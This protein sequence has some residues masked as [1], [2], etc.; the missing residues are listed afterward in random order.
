MPP[1]LEDALTPLVPN[2]ES[3]PSPLVSPRSRNKG[4]LTNRILSVLALLGLV[5]LSLYFQSEVER[6]GI[7]LSRDETHIENLQ[8]LVSSQAEVIARF[9]SSITNSDVLVRLEGLEKSLNRTQADLSNELRKTETTIESRLSETLDQLGQTVAAAQQEIESD[10]DK[11]KKDVESYVRSTQ[12]QFSME[13][14]FMVYQLAGTFTLLSGLI[15]MWHMTAHLRRFNQPV[16]QR[17]ILA[18]LWMCPIYA[19]TSWFSLVFHKA[20]GYLGIVKDFYEAYVIYQFLSFCIAVLGKGDREAVVNLLAKHARHLTPPFRCCGCFCPNPYESDRHLSDAVLLQCQRFAMQ[21]V[22][23]KPLTAITLFTLEKL[24]YYGAGT[25]KTDYRSPQFYIV[26]AQNLSVF[27]AFAGLLKFYH[28]VDQ[29]L[30]WCRPFAK[31]LCIKGVVF[32]TFWQGLAI[33]ILATTTDVGGSDAEE[34]AKSAQNFL[35]CLEMLLFSLAH[36]Y[37]FPTEEWEEGYRASHETGKFGDSIALGDFLQ[38]LK[39]VMRSS[40]KRKKK[41]PSEPTVPE[42]DG[43]DNGDEETQGRAS[44]ASGL[45][46]ESTFDRVDE[47]GELLAGG[48]ESIIN[49]ADVDD[50]EVEEATKRLMSNKIFG[51]DNEGECDDLGEAQTL[52]SELDD[53]ALTYGSNSA[54]PSVSPTQGA[55]GGVPPTETTSLLGTGSSSESLHTDNEEMLRP[56]IFTAVSKFV[57]KPE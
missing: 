52:H 36:F 44:V 14:S 48:I 28:A 6:L 19:I 24:E 30:A 35:I 25:S 17:K 37:C 31:F 46:E 38:D 16:V 12:D 21:F 34:W 26:L 40:K 49:D 41:K 27:I 51:L 9:N 32:M 5:G 53:I 10:V 39:V 1:S 47:E 2:D 43:E 11:V 33:S 18:I 23:L 4:V 42:E 22:F 55:R 13:N 15:S 29:D 45:T 20:E 54:I 8:D 3:S 57:S 7:E 50:P 56:S